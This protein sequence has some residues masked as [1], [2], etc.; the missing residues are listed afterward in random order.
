MAS[1]AKGPVKTLTDAREKKIDYDLQRV[2]FEWVAKTE[3]RKELGRAIEALKEDG[4]FPDLL[5]AAEQ[6]LA[7]LDP[8]Y[9]RKLESMQPVSYEAKRAIDE[10]INSFL[11]D[12]DKMD[13]KLQSATQEDREAAAGFEGGKENRSNNQAGTTQSA[14]SK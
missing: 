11:Q 4:G 14:L 3:D 7:S 1:G 9:R 6:R 13:R 5:K 2:D 8:A 12:M 10:D